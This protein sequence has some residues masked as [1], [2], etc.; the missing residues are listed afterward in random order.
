M[1]ELCQSLQRF[2]EHLAHRQCTK[3]LDACATLLSKYSR[4]LNE[5]GATDSRHNETADYICRARTLGQRLCS[6]SQR[7]LGPPAVHSKLNA[8]PTWE[9]WMQ[10]LHRHETTDEDCASFSQSYIL[11]KWKPAVFSWS[12]VNHSPGRIW[13]EYMHLRKP[14]AD[15][16]IVRAAQI[17]DRYGPNGWRSLTC[18]QGLPCWRDKR[19]GNQTQSIELRLET[20]YMAQHLDRLRRATAFN[21]SRVGLLVEFGGGTGQLARVAQRAGMTGTHVVYDLPPMLMAQ[22]HWLRLAGTPAYHVPSEVPFAYVGAPELGDRLGR[23]V[24]LAPSVSKEVNYELLPRL[25]ADA[26]ARS[27]ESLFIATWS[28]TEASIQARA[29]I[30]PLLSRFDRLF[31]AYRDTW[32]GINN[33]RYLQDWVRR[34]LL[35]TH[36]VCVWEHKIVAVKRSLGHKA[37]CVPALACTKACASW[38]MLPGDVDH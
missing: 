30:R 9:L 14:P 4:A 31:L 21:I 2:E 24:A 34:D 13:L 5:W 23:Q 37:L 35:P 7:L 38:A 36:R 6:D 28:F 12:G 11:N 26:Q 29:P 18:E 22:R 25:L 32:D 16:S 19:D 3:G 1:A 27:V 33:G 15:A 10:E 17:T 8:S 20:I